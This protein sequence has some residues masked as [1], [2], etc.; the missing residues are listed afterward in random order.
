MVYLILTIKILINPTTIH[1]QNLG[2]ANS[3]LLSKEIVGK[4]WFVGGD[5]IVSPTKVV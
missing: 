4:Q 1:H 3:N 2:S 5:K